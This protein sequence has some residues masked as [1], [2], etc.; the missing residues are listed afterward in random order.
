MTLKAHNFYSLL[1]DCGVGKNRFMICGVYAS[2]KEAMEANKEIGKCASRH[3]IKKCEM[4]IKI[5]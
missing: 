3:L 1:C 5:K 4:E 2:K